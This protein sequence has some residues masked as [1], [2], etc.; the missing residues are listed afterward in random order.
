MT[1]DELDRWANLI[2]GMIR[3]EY[4]ELLCRDQRAAWNAQHDCMGILDEI[5]LPYDAGRSANDMWVRVCGTIRFLP[6]TNPNVHY[7]GWKQIWR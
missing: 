5:D 2:D 6:D 1:P 3:G 7:M 4:A